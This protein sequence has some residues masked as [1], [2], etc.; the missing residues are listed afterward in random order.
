MNVSAMVSVV[1]KFFMEGFKEQQKSCPEK[2]KSEHY[3]GVNSR[4]SSGTYVK[5]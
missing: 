2:P 1:Y 5:N 4:I 3:I